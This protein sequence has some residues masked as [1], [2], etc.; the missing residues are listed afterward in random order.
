MAKQPLRLVTSFKAKLRS[1]RRIFFGH[2]E[3]GRHFAFN[4]FS[5]LENRLTYSIKI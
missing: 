1:S 5:R 4:F 2:P 3:S